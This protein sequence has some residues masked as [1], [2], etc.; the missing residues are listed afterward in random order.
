MLPL[1]EWKDLETELKQLKGNHLGIASRV[2][3]QGIQTLEKI[4]IST[5]ETLVQTKTLGP[6]SKKTMLKPQHPV[7]QLRILKLT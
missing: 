5:L 4:K 3:L 7:N 1:K 6:H 2:T